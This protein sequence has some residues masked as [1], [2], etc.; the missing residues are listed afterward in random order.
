MSTIKPEV[1]NTVES[2]SKVAPQDGGCW[3]CFSDDTE[4]EGLFFDWEFDTYVHL[5][6]I[7]KALEKGCEEAR[8]MSYLIKESKNDQ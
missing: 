6:C 7:K 1:T 2:I 5:G 4:K 3:F 8:I